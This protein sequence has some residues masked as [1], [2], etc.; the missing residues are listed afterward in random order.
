[1]NLVNKLFKSHRFNFATG[2]YEYKSDVA[3]LVRRIVRY[4]NNSYPYGCYRPLIHWVMARPERT[5]MLPSCAV[6]WRGGHDQTLPGVPCA[7][8]PERRFIA[9]NVLIGTILALY[10]VRLRDNDLATCLECGEVAGASLFYLTL[11][12]K[13]Q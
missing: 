13:E 6:P 7:G 9:S 5:S 1:M 2:E 8:G 12:A 3:D 10:I 4:C 11:E